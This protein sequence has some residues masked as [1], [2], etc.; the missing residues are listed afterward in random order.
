MGAQRNAN[1]NIIFPMDLNV[2]DL[3]G[4]FPAFEWTRATQARICLGLK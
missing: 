3:S 4:I 1:T 2:L